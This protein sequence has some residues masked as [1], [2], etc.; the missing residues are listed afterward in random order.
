MRFFGWDK[1]NKVLDKLKIYPPIFFGRP[2]G[3]RWWVIFVL[4]AVAM[5]INQSELYHCKL[6]NVYYDITIV[7]SL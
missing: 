1:Q 5:E 7:N 4:S 2:D 6:E 3:Y